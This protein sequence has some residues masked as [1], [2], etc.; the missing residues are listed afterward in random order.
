[1]GQPVEQIGELLDTRLLGAA[2]PH[3]ALRR[4]LRAAQRTDIEVFPEV[5]FLVAGVEEEV[6]PVRRGDDVD[7]DDVRPG[8]HGTGGRAQRVV[9]EASQGRP[10]VRDDQGC[11][12]S[13]DQGIEGGAQV[14]P[15]RRF[16]SER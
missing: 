6:L 4:Q 5:P 11:A 9:G 16:G 8:Q 13:P 12:T 1:M 2:L 14:V 7:L 15:T 10:P 3:E